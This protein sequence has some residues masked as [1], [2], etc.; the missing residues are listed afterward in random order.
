MAM[1]AG[2][3]TNIDT[4]TSSNDTGTGMAFAIY[5]AQRVKLEAGGD[6]SSFISSQRQ[7]LLQSIADF[8]EGMAT[9]IVAHIVASADVTITT[10]DGGLQQVSAADTDPPASNKTLVGAVS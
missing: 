4:A 10:G 5:E 7:T 6:W 3:I 2:T 8:A 1:S 9:G